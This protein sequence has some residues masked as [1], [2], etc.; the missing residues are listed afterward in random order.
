[1][2]GDQLGH[3]ADEVDVLGDRAGHLLELGV[4]G[5]EVADVADAIDLL[6]SLHVLLGAPEGLLSS[7]GSHWECNTIRTLTTEII[8]IAVNRGHPFYDVQKRLGFFDPLPPC[9][10]WATS[11]YYKIHATSFTSVINGWP[12]ILH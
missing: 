12:H 2:L 5:D 6:L 1:M 3:L 10:C 11:L 9:P 4:V 8:T 7:A